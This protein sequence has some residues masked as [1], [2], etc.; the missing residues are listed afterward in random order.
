MRILPHHP[1]RHHPIAIYRTLSLSIHLH[2]YDPFVS[3]PQGPEEEG[4]GEGGFVKLTKLSKLTKKMQVGKKR[5]SYLIM[6]N[7]SLS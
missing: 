4:E 5:N 7:E 2:D 6:A 3:L 1:H